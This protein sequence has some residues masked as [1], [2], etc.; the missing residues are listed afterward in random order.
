[1]T[2]QDADT[3]REVFDKIGTMGADID[4]AEAARLVSDE[5]RANPAAA[6]NLVKVVVGLERERDEI[7]A[8]A[9]ELDAHIAELNGYI[10]QLEAQLQPPPAPLPSSG[11]FGTAQPSPWSRTPAPQPAYEA[12]PQAGPWG[13]PQPQG[14]GFW[15]SALRTGAGVAGGL[16]AFEAMKGIFGGGHEAHA[17]TGERHGFFDGGREVERGSEHPA[18]SGGDHATSGG[19]G[20]DDRSVGSGGIVADN[21]D[22][23]GGSDDV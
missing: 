20:G 11:L 13:A 5:L 19:F 14:G 8:H 10:D 21:I 2:P 12:P 17:H 18:P 9:D 22:F 4:D 15:G 6:L 7:A 16:L 3:I 1:M 23:L